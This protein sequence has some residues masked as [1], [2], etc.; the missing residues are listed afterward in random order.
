MVVCGAVRRTYGEVAGRS[1]ALAAFLVGRGVGLQRERDELERWESGQDPVALVLHNG[2]EYLEAMFGA[3]RAR[4]VP[5][6]VNQHYRAGRGGAPCSPTSAPG[7]SSTTARC[8]WWPL[9]GRRRRLDRR[10]LVLVDVDDGSGVEPL[11]GS[12]PFEEAVPHAG[13]GAGLPVPSPDDLYLVCTGGT[14]GRPKAVL[15]RQAD[16]YVS[17]HG[18]RRGR[19][20]RVDRGR[21]PAAAAPGSRRRRSCTPPPSGPPSRAAQR[22]HRRPP[23]RLPALRRPS[24]SSTVAERERVQADV[25]RRRRLRRP[26]RRGAAPAALRPVVAAAPRHRRRRHRRAAQGGAA[27]AA[28]APHD[29][30]RLRRVRDRRHGLR[31]P[32]PGDAGPAAFT[33]GAGADVVSDDRSRFLDAGRRRDRVDGPPG[34]RAARLPRRPGA[35]RGDVPGRRRRAG[36]DPRRPGP[37][38][39]R[40]HDPRCS[41]ATR[42]W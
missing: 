20:R 40:R 41:A 36:G 5:F 24:A 6:N 15:W 18:G 22:R 25:D 38:A 11:P 39:R 4:A 31:G 34:P 32:Q 9:R 16:I 1:R 37:A 35:H 42:W 17:G 23:R 2:V 30:R 13:D 3:Y 29:H 21:P 7:R 33:P 28:P 10:R 26:A 12:T 8:R 14:T 19:H 27:R